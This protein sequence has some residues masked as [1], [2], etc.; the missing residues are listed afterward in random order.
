M[1]ASIDTIN[2]KTRPSCFQVFL[3]PFNSQET[4]LIRQLYSRATLFMEMQVILQF[5]NLKKLFSR[6]EKFLFDFG[7][8]EKVTMAL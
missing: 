6:S 3:L 7:F 5:I 1:T 2:S 8:Q 4:R